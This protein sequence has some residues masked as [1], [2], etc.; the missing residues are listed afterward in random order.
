MIVRD[1]A[2][3]LA[4]CLARHAPAVDEI[5]VVDTGSRDATP[6]VARTAG[7]AVIDF[8]WRDDFAAARNVGLDAVAADRILVLDPDERI[9]AADLPRLRDLANRETAWVFHTRNYLSGPTPRARAV[10]EADRQEAPAGATHWVDSVKVRLWPCRPDVRFEGAVH[11]VVD[12]AC[13]RAGLPIDEA[14]VPIHHAGMMKTRGAEEKNR[15]YVEI[16]RREVRA[17]STHPNLLTIVAEAERRSGRP[18]EAARLLDRAIRAA[19]FFGPAHLAL[20]DLQ[21]SLGETDRAIETLLA[22]MR[23]APF[24]RDLPVEAVRLLLETGDR[25]SAAVL[26]RGALAVHPGDL[27]LLALLR[28]GEGG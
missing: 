9:A 5:V 15:R 19:P 2:D 6:D 7:A 28:R 10:A 13:L 11:E 20:A 24:W 25:A 21:R 18:V 17:G 23:A 4:A 12:F 8:A 27:D 14:P 22:G 26:A 3:D 1:C 16:A